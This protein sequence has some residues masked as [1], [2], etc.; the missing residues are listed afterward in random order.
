MRVFVNRLY[1][2]PTH[3]TKNVA[4]MGHPAVVRVSMICHLALA[5]QNVAWMG[6]PL[7]QYPNPFL[8]DSCGFLDEIGSWLVHSFV[9]YAG[10]DDGAFGAR[11]MLA[12]DFFESAEGEMR[13]DL[14]GGDVGVAEKCLHAAEVCSVFHHVRSAAMTEHVR[15]GVV[16]GHFDQVPDPLT[17]KRHAAEREK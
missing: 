4:W 12:V 17:G 10:F 7:F 6:H 11:V 16:V 5:A 14:R 1:W 8:P 9:S 13:I 2:Y 15:A 3:A